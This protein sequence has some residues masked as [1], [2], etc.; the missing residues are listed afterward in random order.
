M[1]PALCRQP[2]AAPPQPTCHSTAVLPPPAHFS[3]PNHEALRATRRAAPGP[4]K[5]HN[6]SGSSQGCNSTSTVEIVEHVCGNA[7]VLRLKASL[8]SQNIMALEFSCCAILPT[9]C[10][11]RQSTSPFMGSR[12][13]PPLSRTFDKS[14]RFLRHGADISI[15]SGNCRLGKIRNGWFSKLSTWLNFGAIS[16]LGAWVAASMRELGIDLPQLWE[17]SPECSPNA[18]IVGRNLR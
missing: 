9:Y 18:V 2:L 4:A 12:V 1:G 10:I 15:C 11:I 6:R 16:F 13:F 3:A 7:W 17:L 14:A 8:W 5:Q